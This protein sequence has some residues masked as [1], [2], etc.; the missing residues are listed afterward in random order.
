MLIRWVIPVRAEG[1]P[2][3]GIDRVLVA[4]G[5]RDQDPRIRRVRQHGAKAVAD[6]FAQHLHRVTGT[7]D[8]RLDARGAG[9]THVTGGADAAFEQPRLVI[10]AVGIQV[11]VRALEAHR[12][13][14]AL[15]GAHWHHGRS[16]V[17]RVIAAAIPGQRDARRHAGHRLL[18]V[19]FEAHT[20]FQRL[21]QAGDHAGQL[22]VA[23]FQRCR[24]FVGEAQLRQSRRPGEAERRRG[25]D[26]Q[27]GCRKS[28]YRRRRLFA[29]CRLHLQQMTAQDEQQHHCTDQGGQPR[30][31][32]QVRLLLQQ[33]DA[34]GEGRNEKAHGALCPRQEP[35]TVSPCG[36]CPRQEPGTVSPCGIDHAPDIGRSRCR[37]ISRAA[38]R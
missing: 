10:E 5:E 27:R 13:A 36:V 16:L 25:N 8:L 38:R 20:A 11:A 35:G 14:P 4:D 32:A 37:W 12:E 2:E 23:A 17:I 24:Q 30:Q 7:P 29:I 34:G 3:S 6:G 21:R 15:T 1:L 26:Q 31:A 19:E 18:H 22:H 33:P 28:P 9:G